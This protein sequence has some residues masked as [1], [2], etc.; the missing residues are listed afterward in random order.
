M[1]S[2]PPPWRTR[3]PRVLA[4]LVTLP[5]LGF[6]R[7]CWLTSRYWGTRWTSLIEVSVWLGGQRFAVTAGLLAALCFG[8]WIVA[9]DAA[10]RN[11]AVLRG[12]VAAF[13]TAP[14]TLWASALLLFMTDSNAQGDDLRWL[15]RINWLDTA[16][17]YLVR[18][19]LGAI[20]L[21]F[22]PQ[23]VGTL[24]GLVIW[25]LARAPAP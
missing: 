9:R 10:T 8:R 16:A 18:P 22:V 23:I 1:S 4:G 2:L 14:L 20:V 6:S 25:R 12:F 24:T 19:F 15:A 5:S 13:P 11:Q 17:D 21:L 3:H 7:R